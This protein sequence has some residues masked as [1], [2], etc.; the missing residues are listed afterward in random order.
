[1]NTVRIA[2]IGYGRMGK[3]VE[4]M[5]VKRGHSIACVID[6]E[7]D[8]AQ[9]ASLLSEADVAI[10]FSLPQTAV[11]NIR[12]CFAAN[13]PLVEGTTGWNK[14]LETVI[15]ECNA[16]KQTL[17]YAPNYS[18]GMNIMF[19]LNKQ[20]AGLLNRTN[21]RVSLTEAHHIHKLDAPSG[22]AVQLL[23]QLIAGID[24]YKGWDFDGKQGNDQIPVSVI[25]E[26]EVH[27]IHE[28]VANSA[29][30]IISIR[31]E[32]KGR[33]G[34]ALGAVMAAEFL[35]GKKGIFTMDDLM[36]ALLKG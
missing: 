21:Y 20:L 30:D 34:L 23:N 16:A 27:G 12:R 24:R 5:A 35:V 22:T 15:S 33:Q 1:M 31:H 19:L 26:G 3:E 36:G 29:E 25:R 8:W 17:F 7:T 10:D 18:L 4:K 6:N 11:S 14:D 28:V 9:K 32:A 13:L 2:L